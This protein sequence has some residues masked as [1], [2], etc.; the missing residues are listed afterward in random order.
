MDE[1][2]AFE[3]YPALVLAND[4]VEVVVITRGASIVSV[5]G[6][7]DE[8]RQS[9]L[10]N[11]QEAAREQGQAH[12]A[13]FAKSPG[14]GHFVC[15]D[16]FGPGSP[17]EQQ[18]GLPMH[19]EAHRQLYDVRHHSKEGGI[20]AL[21]LEAMLPL[22][23]EVFRRTLRLVDGEKVLYVESEL[24]SLLAF[25]RPVVWAEHA[26]IGAP[27]LRREETVVDMP[28]ARA[29]TRDHPTHPEVL[30]RR[31]ASGREFEWP[32]APGA[33]GTPVDIRAVGPGASGDHTTCLMEPGRPWAFV[34]CLN[35][36]SC[37]LLGY[38]F[39]RDEFPWLQNWEHYPADR[40]LAR[41]LEFATQPYD[42][43]R[44]EAVQAGA[45]FDTPTYRWLPARA[46]ITGRFLLFWTRTP[47]GFTKI[48][49]LRIESGTVRVRD[50]SGQVMVLP[51]SLAG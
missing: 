33:D 8:E 51:A 21:T 37:R 15:L 16:G 10:W 41:G 4:E 28:A 23:G 12:G 6:H 50:V 40:Q 34:T 47:A 25:D 17:E 29:R 19:G 36:T 1:T 13:V 26:T 7:D 46:K 30:V 24:E 45:M 3:G 27:F 20:Q 5:I 35:P 22:V 38:L 31:L 9:P 2:I 32:L 18:A 42:V 48:D 11:P 39:R 49:D 44:R 43:P 14:F